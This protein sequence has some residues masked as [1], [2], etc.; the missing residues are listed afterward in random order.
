MGLQA[1]ITVEDQFGR[2]VW[3]IPARVG[4]RGS[5]PLNDPNTFEE[6]HVD[7]AGHV[8][9]EYAARGW[10]AKTGRDFGATLFTVHFNFNEG[11]NPD[12][13]HYNHASIDA[14]A[15]DVG[16]SVVL[17]RDGG[18][19]GGG[20]GGGGTT[21]TEVRC[22]S[23]GFN[24]LG[25]PA[26]WKAITH[27]IVSRLPPGALMEPDTGPQPNLV[28]VHNELLRVHPWSGLQLSGSG[29]LKPRVFGVSLLHDGSGPPE[30]PCGQYSRPFDIGSFGQPFFHDNEGHTDVWN[31]TGRPPSS[32]W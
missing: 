10:C 26:E 24:G 13:M 18:G 16:M 29:T 19:N 28:F 8:H 9:V 30:S 15:S 4:L 17:M 5:Q 14:D 1:V 6:K 3:G 27:G 20:N 2:P 12:W 21:L 23:G 32:S 31:L 25:T 11:F 7:R 22:P